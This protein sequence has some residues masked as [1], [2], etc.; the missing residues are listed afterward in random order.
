MM[1]EDN[2]PNPR[3]FQPERWLRGS[4]TYRPAHPCAA[5]PFGMGP[6]MCIGRRFA[7]LEVYVAVIKLLQQFRLEYRYEP[8]GIKVALI[9][10]PDRNIKMMFVPRC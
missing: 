8:V 2:F 3:L 4:P 6:R 7:E 5:L 9:Q 1:D 10:K